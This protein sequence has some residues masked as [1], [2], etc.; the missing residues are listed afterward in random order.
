M[1]IVEKITVIL[2][3]AVL[4]AFSGSQFYLY[5]LIDKT[6]PTISCQEDELWLSVSATQQ[7]LLRGVSARDDRDGDLTDRIIVQGITPLLEGDVARVT[8]VV[9]DSSDNMASCQRTIHYTDYEEPHFFLT[10]PLIYPAGT[11]IRLLDRLGA[12]DAAGEDISG[13]IRVTSQNVSFNSEGL[14]HITVQAIDAL[15]DTE[16]LTLPLVINNQM[17]EHQELTLTDYI[18][19]LA[20]GDAFRSEDYIVYTEKE[21]ARKSEIKKFLSSVK[22]EGEVD[23]GVPGV[24]EVSYTYQGYTVIQTVIVK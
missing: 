18:L 16:I 6:P 9:F 23:T 22:V 21:N 3:I 24:Y 14:Y 13:S 11:E 15:G 7:Q 5:R 17:A 10:A 12:V 19:Y 8:Y 2:F 20:K 1:K 4:L